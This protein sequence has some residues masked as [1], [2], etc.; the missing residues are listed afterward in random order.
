MAPQ[1]CLLIGYKKVITVSFVSGVNNLD[2]GPTAFRWSKLLYTHVQGMAEGKL[3]PASLSAPSCTQVLA[4]YIMIY[5][6][7]QGIS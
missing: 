1:T 6:I 2:S 5:I 7:Y 3:L 4:I